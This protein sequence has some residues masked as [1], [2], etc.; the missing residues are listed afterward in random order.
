LSEDNLYEEEKTVLF[1]P[2]YSATWLNCEAALLDGR[3]YPDSAGIDAARGTVFHDV[4]A[5]WLRLGRRPY[6]RKGQIAEVWPQ[7]IDDKTEPFLIEI[8]QDM[9]HYGKQCVEYLKEIPGTRYIEQKIDISH[10]TPIKNQSGTGDV[11]ICD[12]GF[13]NIGD[14][15]YGTGVKVFA[16]DNSQ[17]LLY[18]SGAFE[19]WD[20]IYHFDRIGMH[21]LQPR[22]N[23]FDY[24]EISREELLKWNEWA[25]EKAKASMRRKGRTYTVGVKQCTWCKRRDDC[26]AK[27]V[28]LEAIADESFEAYEPITA[29]EAK[30]VT[31]FTPPKSMATTVQRLSTGELAEL[32]KYRKLFETWFRRIGEVLLER[33][34]EGE[35]IGEYYITKG[36]VN[37]HWKKEKEIIEK[38]LLIGV[39]QKEL[40]TPG[41]LKSPAQMEKILRSYGFR[42]KTGKE[43]VNLHIDMPPGK[44]TLVRKGEDDRAEIPDYTEGFESEV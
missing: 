2:S 29:K 44:P 27:L 41:K 25:K 31:V 34:L 1:R 33:G 24:W 12:W 19:E 30:A 21:I 39:P 3:Y 22:L 11:I 4:I 9:F 15:K 43:Y 32:Y 13:L 37:R 23:H 6:Y 17:L 40:F 16:K 7:E 14:H 8:D 42:G 35:D 36:R 26:R 38:L 28:A 18:A 20:W 5:E 10:I